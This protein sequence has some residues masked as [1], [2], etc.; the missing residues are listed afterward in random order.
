[1]DVIRVNTAG[2][3]TRKDIDSLSAK[4]RDLVPLAKFQDLAKRADN[5][6]L[7]SDLGDANERIRALQNALQNYQLKS[8]ASDQSHGLI[9]VLRKDIADSTSRAA[10]DLMNLISKLEEDQKE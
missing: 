3:A 5:F 8:D 6:A 9:D 7:N 2:F 10:K 4:M 1:M